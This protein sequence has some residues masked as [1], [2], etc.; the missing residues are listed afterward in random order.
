MKVQ[1]LLN[2]KTAQNFFHDS[3]FF[4]SK[5]RKGVGITV[6]PDKSLLFKIYLEV[7]QND[8][9]SK[10]SSILG[11]RYNTFIK[12]KKLANFD[13]PSSFAIGKKISS[14]GKLFNYYHIKF[15]EKLFF[16]DY[17]YKLNLLNL[18]KC[19]RGVS[20][21]YNEKEMFRKKYFYIKDD[22][23][24]KIVNNLFNLKLNIENIDHFEIYSKNKNNFK[25]NYIFKNEIKDVIFDNYVKTIIDQA[26]LL[27]NKT[28]I[29][30]GKTNTNDVS[31]YYSFTKE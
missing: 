28:P 29:Y 18:S 10:F 27:F 31:I 25:I 26:N 1:D 17:Y 14:S 22:E 30:A 13:L 5:N 20:Y 7:K 2:S 12:F 16:K 23:N 6:F 24:K 4:Y 9:L 3:N 8:N 21:E 15:K 19:D 11:S